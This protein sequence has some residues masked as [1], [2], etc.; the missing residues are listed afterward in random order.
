MPGL[1]CKGH[2]KDLESFRQGV[3]KDSSAVLDLNIPQESKD[4]WWKSNE[5]EAESECTQRKGWDMRQN[6]QY[7]C[8]VAEKSVSFDPGE[9]ECV[10]NIDESCLEEQALKLGVSIFDAY[11]S[12]CCVQKNQDNDVDMCGRFDS[13]KSCPAKSSPILRDDEKECCTDAIESSM[14]VVFERLVSVHG[15]A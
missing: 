14:Y 7:H 11:S 8:A 4:F 12:V 9:C 3:L 1:Y 13:T 6:C 15:K 5:D 2:I 10:A